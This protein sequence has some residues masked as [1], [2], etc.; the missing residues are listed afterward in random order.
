MTRRQVASKLKQSVLLLAAS[1]LVHLWAIA[2]NRIF[3]QSSAF[4]DISLYNYWSFQV[5]QGGPI[6][7][8]EVEWVYPALAFIPIWFASLLPFEYETAWL[9][10]VFVLNSSVVLA[11]H[12]TRK[13]ASDFSSWYF[14]AGLLLLGPVAISRIDIFALA[15]S[16]IAVILVGSARNQLATAFLTIAGW[17]KVW[18]VAIFVSLAASLRQNLRTFLVA[19]AISAGIILFGFSVQGPTVLGFLS[20]QQSRGLQIESVIATPWM[21]LASLGQADI[22]FDEI[23][24]TNQVRAEGVELLASVWNLMLIAAVIGIYILA[25]NAFNRGYSQQSVFVFAS[26]AAVSSLI[27]FNKVGSPQFMLWL[28]APAVAASYFS[29]A[30][31]KTLVLATAFILLLTQLLYPVL[32]IELLSL[33][34]LPLILLTVRNAL[35]ILVL[36]LSCLSLARKQPL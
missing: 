7:G 13:V 21:W 27:V 9:I 17:I 2:A 15:L 24:L 35:L 8:L 26:F 25:R 3:E 30:K 34:V 6:Y 32:Y 14:L 31:A 12:F 16:I 23:V 18:P 22:Y 36:A 11:L 28:I 10:L 4:G 33:E 1:V 19:G 20:A 5:N 29:V